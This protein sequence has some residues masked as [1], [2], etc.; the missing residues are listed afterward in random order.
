MNLS[1]CKP[2]FGFKRKHILEMV[3]HGVAY[4]KVQRQP[5]QGDGVDL[6]IVSRSLLKPWQFLACDVAGEEAYWAIGMASHSG[7]PQHMEALDHLLT[8]GQATEDD[9]ICPRAYPLDWPTAARLKLAG[10][11]PRRL[12]H[13]CSGKHL[14]MIASCRKFNFPIDTYWHE[15]HPLQE[16]LFALVGKEA[17]ERIAWVTDGCGLPTVE[18]PA[19]AHLALW[20]KLATDESPKIRELRRLWLSSPRL[21]GGFKRLDSDLVEAM[22]G[23]ILVKEGADGLLLVQS[24]PD[25]G[26]AV[27]TVMIKLAA[28]HNVPYLALALWSRLSTT[29]GLPKVFSDLTDYLR[30]RLEEWVPDDLELVLPPY[31]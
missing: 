22:K 11:K 19:R 4:T 14:L 30:A 28:G 27:G 1:E 10:E 8:I 15:D 21:V 25:N 23:R 13:P 12:H 20:E 31:T 2:L 7:Q 16:K 3:I 17:N 5:A 9:L 26:E 6:P 18:M 29:T 24:L